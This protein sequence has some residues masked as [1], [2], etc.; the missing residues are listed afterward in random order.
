[1]AK[2]LKLRVE[3][4][5]DSPMA[6][7]PTV[8]GGDN[9]AASY[10]LNELGIKNDALPSTPASVTESKIP[11]VKDMC[12]R[13]AIYQLERRGI[14]VQLYGTGRVKRQSLAA[15][16]EIKKGMTCVLELQ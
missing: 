7:V 3:D 14:K 5:R 13:D 9:T 4:A 10:V 11:D 1:M 16:S 8:K 12:A 6:F 2:S 15:G